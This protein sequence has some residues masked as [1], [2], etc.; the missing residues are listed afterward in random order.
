MKLEEFLIYGGY[1][2]V[3]MLPNNTDKAYYLENLVN[4]LLLKDILELERVKS[5]QVVMKLLQLL[6]F[7]IG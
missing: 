1:P 3:L 7:Q 5:S 6:A 4:S 2:E